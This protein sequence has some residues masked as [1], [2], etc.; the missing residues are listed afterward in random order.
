MLTCKI[1]ATSSAAG[2][3]TDVFYACCCNIVCCQDLDFAPPTGVPQ[4]GDIIAEYC[5]SASLGGA[6]RIAPSTAC[7]AQNQR[8]FSAIK[9]QIAHAAGDGGR[10]PLFDS[11][12]QRRS[13]LFGRIQ[14]V[15]TDTS[16]APRGNRRVFL[17]SKSG[18]SR[19]R[20]ITG[21]CSFV[22]Y[23]LSLIFLG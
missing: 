10:S 4:A 8:E 1:A 7:G 11:I 15:F 16:P 22:Q 23:V 12:C 9:V 2:F 17:E 5:T 14:E 13:E 3:C 6:L 20:I 21:L 19:N 18:G